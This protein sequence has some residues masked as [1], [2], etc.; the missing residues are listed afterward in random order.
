MV[1]VDSLV[2]L[3]PPPDLPEATQRTEEQWLRAWKH[4]AG[5]DSK[6]VVRTLA[7]SRKSI[8]TGSQWR[9]EWP[10]KAATRFQKAS[11]CQQLGSQRVGSP[12]PACVSQVAP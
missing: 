5:R 9:M 11:R 2:Q 6:R 12:S 4:L 8:F 7:E 1:F 3:L 10:K